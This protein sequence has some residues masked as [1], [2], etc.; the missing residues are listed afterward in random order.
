MC[1]HFLST[2]LQ[3]L[4]FDPIHGHNIEISHVLLLISSNAI[5]DDPTEELIRFGFEA[6]S[7]LDFKNYF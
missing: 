4:Y 3:I 1:F 2:D 6:V 7:I 5:P